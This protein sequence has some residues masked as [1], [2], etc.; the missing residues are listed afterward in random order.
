[1]TGADGRKY[2]IDVYATWSE[3]MNSGGATGRAVKLMTVVVRDQGSPYRAWAR[4]A[5]TFDISTGS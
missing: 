4:V 2:R 1:V 3:V 5:S